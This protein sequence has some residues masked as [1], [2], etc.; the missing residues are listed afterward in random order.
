[1]IQ[2]IQAI[3]RR[4]W[5]AFRDKHRFQEVMVVIAL[6]CLTIVAVL[7]LKQVDAERRPQIEGRVEAVRWSHTKVIYAWGEEE[8]DEWL[9]N[10]SPRPA[11]GYLEDDTPVPG[12]MV[13]DCED[14]LNTRTRR[15]E[16]MCHYKSWGWHVFDTC[17]ESGDDFD[18]YPPLCGPE[19][20][21][22]LRE[23]RDFFIQVRFDFKGMPHRATIMP[24]DEESFRMY[25]FKLPAY[26][27]MSGDSVVGVS[28]SGQEISP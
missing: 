12:L 7:Y 19:S 26:V 4:F 11:P 5:A 21:Q 13:Y 18:I 14:L 2:R 10:L 25:D 23:F 3:A 20:G 9:S 28:P 22:Y 27:Q 17:T 24:E 8:G 6:A 16:K 15:V 1:M